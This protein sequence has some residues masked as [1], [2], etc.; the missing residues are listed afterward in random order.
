[1]TTAARDDGIRRHRATDPSGNTISICDVKEQEIYFDVREVTPR[2]LAARYWVSAV[3]V[4][5]CYS[6]VMEPAPEFARAWLR[7]RDAGA[8]AVAAVEERELAN[9]EDTDALRLA[10]ALLSAVP[11]D[12]MGNDRRATS[13]LIE[14]QR[15]FARARKR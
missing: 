1:V 6:C 8:A 4:K 15:Q 2:S 12:A 5:A 10:D 7:Q 9:L 14:Q 11:T 3:L 13:G